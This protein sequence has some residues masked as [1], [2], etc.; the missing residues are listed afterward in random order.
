MKNII[1]ISFLFFFSFSFSQT[2]YLNKISKVKKRTYTYKTIDENKN[3][4]LDLYYP[5]KI[6]ENVPLVLFVHGGGFSG[7]K[8]NDQ[9]TVGFANE[10]AQ[11]GYAVASISY[12]LTMR[13]VG[14]GCNTDSNLKIK[15]FNDASEDI[16]YAV[17]YL[18]NH[19]EKLNIDTNRIIL[20]GNSAGAEAVLNLAYVYDN[21]ILPEKFKFA[22]VI[23]MAGAITT[24][25]KI[26]KET[27]IPTQLFHG[28]EDLLVPYN[29]APHHYCNKDSKGYLT[30]YGG[31]AIAEKLKKMNKSFYLY[32]INNGDHSWSG[33]PMHQC[34]KEIID[35]LYTDVIKGGNR[36][37]DIKI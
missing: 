18:I 30:L 8:R 15:A 17:Q 6:K 23:G 1:L 27:A 21:K 34:I 35:F 11:Y 4:K 13:K 5:K 37:V 10:I 26:N 14:F 19:K 7:G 29:I 36:Q 16:S 3:L 28:T 12:R 25:D 24:L 31:K 20:M 22:G 32:T 2:L 9:L 33:R